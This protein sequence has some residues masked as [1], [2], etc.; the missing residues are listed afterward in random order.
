MLKQ[1][2]KKLN[3]YLILKIRKHLIVLFFKKNFCFCSDSIKTILM[4]I[5]VIEENL[6][7][8]ILFEGKNNNK[9]INLKIYISCIP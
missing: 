8:T 3:G 5:V 1:N 6:F 4:I 2:F 7:Y 9:K